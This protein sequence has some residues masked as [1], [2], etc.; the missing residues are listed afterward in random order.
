[1]CG[2]QEDWSSSGVQ[3]AVVVA[4]VEVVQLKNT[5]DVAGDLELHASESFVDHGLRNRETL[6]QL[7]LQLEG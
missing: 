5:S 7:N 6:V 2:R 1:M 4:Q 3:V